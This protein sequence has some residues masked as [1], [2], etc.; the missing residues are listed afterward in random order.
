MDGFDSIIFLWFASAMLVTVI[1]YFRGQAAD[2][3]TLGI[4]LGPIALMVTVVVVVRGCLPLR[5]SPPILEDYR[6]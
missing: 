5:E 6:R 4:L 2:A 3:M 1:G